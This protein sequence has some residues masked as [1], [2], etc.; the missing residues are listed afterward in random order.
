PTQEGLYK[1]YMAIA[2]GVEIPQI[3]YNVPGRTITD[4]SN[5][6]A[7]KLAEHPNIIGIKDATGDM[8]RGKALIEN[9]PQGFKI[10]SG[11]DLTATELMLMGAK[12]NISVTANVVPAQMSALCELAI[13]GQHQQA[14]ALQAQLTPLHNALFT[15]ANPIPVKWAL[16]SMGL[17]PDGIR[18][19]LTP[20][21]EANADQLSHAMNALNIN[22]L[23][24]A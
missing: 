10:Y 18:L 23:A 6:V 11:D 16:S 14:R 20:L 24:E 22:L 3:L 4:M 2:N 19:P 21:T 12:G 5:D 9:A 13:N 8:V 1:H 15:E 17:M 7:L